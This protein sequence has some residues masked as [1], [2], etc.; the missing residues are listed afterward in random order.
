MKLSLLCNMGQKIIKVYISV[1]MCF[2]IEKLEAN[3]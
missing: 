2:D 3:F 1:K